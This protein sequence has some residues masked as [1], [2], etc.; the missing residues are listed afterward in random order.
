M[1]RE[2]T[3]TV[4]RRVVV[5]CCM[6]VAGV[7]AV[8]PTLASAALPAVT[9]DV[10]TTPLSHGSHRGVTVTASCDTGTLVGG[11]GYL[12]NATDPTILPTNGLVLG[13]V[14]PSAGLSPVDEAVPDGAIDPS[15]WLTI[16][17]F[18]GQAELGDQATS[19]ALCATGGATA[20]VV[21]A[22]ETVGA[23]ATQ[24]VAPP[25]RTIATCAPGT[26]LIGGAAMTRTPDQVSDGVT[27]GGS[28][29]LKPMGSYPSDAAGTPALDGATDATSWTAYGSAGMTTPGD[30]VIAYALCATGAGAD[31]PVEVARTDVDGP[32]AQT[33]STPLWASATCPTDTRLLGGG[34]SVDQTVGA[35]GGLQP[36]QGYHMRGSFPATDTGGR[37][38]VGPGA[39]DPATWTALVQ[40]GGQNLAVGS[41]M[42]IRGFALCAGEPAPPEAAALTLDLEAT[43]TPAVVGQRLTYALTL[44]NDGPATATDV[45]ATTTLP[46]NATYVSADAEQGTCSHAAGTVTCDVGELADGERTSATIVVVPTDT[47][48]L[49]AGAI[50]DA[51]MPGA[52]ATKSLTTPVNAAERAV[53]QLTVTT[54]DATL[55][56]PL[57]AQA[58]LSGG[59]DPSGTVAFT[60]YG[61][62]DH[63]C[64]SPLATSDAPV[65][66]NGTY[67]AAPYV[68]TT[69][70]G[71]RW[72]ARYDGDAANAPSGPSS[73]GDPAAAAAVQAVPTLAVVAEGGTTVGSVL[74]AQATLDGA[75]LASGTIVLDLHGPGDESCARPLAS[76]AV[77]VFGNGAYRAPSHVASVPGTYRWVARYDGNELTRPAGTAC[78][79]P[80]AAITVV[81]APSQPT[82]PTAPAPAPAPAKA[83]TV[84][85]AQADRSGRITLR[86]RTP[87]A[88][89]LRVV[90]TTRTTSRGRTRTVRYGTGT[91]TV[92][93]AT[94]PRLVIAP[95][96][97]AKSL[98][99]S[100]AR[101]RVTL[102]V[103]FTPRKGKTIVR[104]VRTAVTGAKR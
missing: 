85:K 78:A 98:R 2:R 59:T 9:V 51:T 61:P 36:Q 104:T 28:G 91:V 90:A 54:A 69:A 67:A 101:L 35:V 41:H 79:D 70:G 39:T 89:R 97:A 42:T 1:A 45:V 22:A 103:T 86:P 19:F 83:L 24:Q 44:G 3:A 74:T 48:P 62:G 23:N 47:T 52:G 25:T 80:A 7:G 8:A 43:P 14:A 72:V 40:A 13:G 4:R 66:G 65:T 46:A 30:K 88:G 71:Y 92:R 68:A 17:N 32:D 87:G 56:G 15:R 82:P 73:C 18:T 26:R 102:R 55:G 64:A 77:A 96:R 38:E 58:T 5:A 60:L 99:R 93:S 76:S 34:Y 33:G 20:T 37:T 81:G 12:R 27:V 100:H 10:V 63:D 53:T 75:V 21:R 16:A 11:G 95:T 6:T 57:T 31:I 84:G 50:V 94:R 29:N 49:V